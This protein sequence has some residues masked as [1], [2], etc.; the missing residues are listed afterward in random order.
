METIIIISM[1]FCQIKAEYPDL[2]YHIT[3]QWLF[4]VVT[5]YCYIVNKGPRLKYF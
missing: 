2:L 5:L 1:N 4:A 3:V